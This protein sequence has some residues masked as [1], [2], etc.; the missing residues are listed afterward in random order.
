MALTALLVFKTTHMR[1]CVHHQAFHVI[2]TATV[3]AMQA[4]ILLARIVKDALGTY[5]R[6]DWRRIGG[7]SVVFITSWGT[8]LRSVVGFVIREIKLNLI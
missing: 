5:E 7:A 8:D 2:V 4:T 1:L 3:I 6:H